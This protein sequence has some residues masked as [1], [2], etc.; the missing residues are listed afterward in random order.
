MEKLNFAVIGSGR[1]GRNYIRLIE[2][3]SNARLLAVAAK[4]EASFPEVK[5]TVSGDV[6]FTTRYQNILKSKKIDSVVISTPPSTHFEIAKKAIL[7]GKNILLEKPMA[8]ALSDAK[9]LK[10]LL[11][12]YSGTFMVGHQYCYNDYFKYLQEQISSG[13]FG[14]IKFVFGEHFYPGPWSEAGVLWDAG[15]HKLSM[16]QFLLGSMKI[17]NAS[18]VSYNLLG[19]GTDDYSQANTEF[20]K[21]RMSLIV[22]WTYPRRSRKLFIFGAKKTA[23]YDEYSE[24]KLKIYDILSDSKWHRSIYAD[25]IQN[26][27]KI[28]F[29]APK[30]KAKNPLENQ[31]NHFIY[32]IKNRKEPVT[33]FRSSYQITEWLDFISRKIEVPGYRS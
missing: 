17:K 20:D 25:S 16:V 19:N 14:K 24:E 32:C 1:F 28:K 27:E 30:I 5:K 21:V 4:S 2:G 13:K 10:L 33:D 8:L 29:T 22:S 26:L 9:K 6:E 15:T 3:F 11:K 18:G 7:A 23:V 12:N 31:L